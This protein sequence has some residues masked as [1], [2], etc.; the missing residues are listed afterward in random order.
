MF[1]TLST[2][3]GSFALGIAVL[4]SQA[5]CEKESPPGGPAATNDTTS[6]ATNTNPSGTTDTAKDGFKLSVPSTRTVI[7]PGARTEVAIKISRDGN[8][9]EPVELT[10]KAPEGVTAQAAKPQ[11]EPNDAE[12]MLTLEAAADAKPGEASIEVTGTPQTGSPTTVAVPIE[13]RARTDS[14]K[15]AAPDGTAPAPTAPER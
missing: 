4:L 1:R 3:A 9:K 2:T 14:A 7:E 10:F 15:P 11:F 6:N 12:V 5:G 8:F 13:V